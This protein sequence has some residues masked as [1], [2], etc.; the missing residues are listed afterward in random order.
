MAK[1]PSTPPEKHVVAE[2]GSQAFRVLNFERYAVRT[3]APAPVLATFPHNFRYQVV[4]AP[5]EWAG[6]VGVGWK[7][8]QG[9]GLP[10]SCPWSRRFGRAVG[11][12][13]Q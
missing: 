4:G 5:A 6:R 3:A 12:R 10:S 7:G 2:A 8:T 1:K 11:H 13:S 9:V